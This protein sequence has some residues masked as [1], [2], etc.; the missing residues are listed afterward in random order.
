MSSYT[1][2]RKRWTVNE[3]LDLQREFELLEWSIDEIAVKHKRT[4]N[5]IM[6]KL[7][8]E[9]FANYNVLCNQYYNLDFGNNNVEEENN[10]VNVTSCENNKYTNKNSCDYDELKN[11]IKQLEKQLS[12][13]TQMI[14]TQNKNSKNVLSLFE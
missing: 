13:L 10:N 7:D 2:N 6:N 4:P 5:S 3:C 8:K 9:G 1:R 12:S 11:H 14:M